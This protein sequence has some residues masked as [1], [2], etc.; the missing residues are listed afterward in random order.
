M[1]WGFVRLA[2]LLLI[3]FG[4]LILTYQAGFTDGIRDTAFVA[5]FVVILI[6]NLLLGWRA[7]AVFFGLSVLAGWAFAYAE[8]QGI[9]VGEIVSA[10][11]LA[12]DITVIFGLAAI[13]L[14]LTTASLGNALQ[15]ARDSERS[16]TDS[17]RELRTLSQSLEQ[18]VTAR[19]QRLQVIAALTEHLNAIL[20]LDELLDEVVNQLKDNF[21]YYHAHIYLMDEERER[22]VVRAGTGQAGAE[23]KA[24]GHSI[25]M[26][27]ATSLVVQAARTGQPVRIDNVQESPD[28]LPNP[29]LPDTR[30]EMVIPI[31]LEQKVVGVLDV[32]KDEVAGLDEGD[33]SLLRSLANQMAVAIRNARLFSEVE[34]A[35]N[36]AREAQQKYVEQSWRESK[37]LG[38]VRHLYAS[39]NINIGEDELQRL[40]D[41]ARK[42]ALT[43]KQPVIVEDNDSLG[44]SL[45]AP[46]NLRE[47][48]IGVFRIRQK[49]GGEQ[50]SWNE[51]DVAMIEAIIDQ[52]AQTAESL[53][54]FEETRRRAGREQ[55]IR[56]VTEHMRA[57]T[58]LD[59]LIRIT[60]EELGQRLS[61]KYAL[62]K[63]GLDTLSENPTIQIN[64]YDQEKTEEER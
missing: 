52:A 48:T 25:S 39:P 46:I 56:Q 61:A 5:Y 15:R 27:A 26:Q 20:N 38:R 47:K 24:R 6:A 13:T 51:D 36:E 40:V 9:I 50:Q 64:D 30:A 45:I 31:I 8:E 10:Y 3:S 63:L 55:T 18:Q 58:N 53:R 28:W 7:G 14:A 37:V 1:R 42:H 33:A 21:N 57:A 11:D 12:L 29:L 17:N 4:W 41:D 44:K 22:L 32:Q 59:E 16:L 34:T 62:V 35:L 19:T 23:M 2:S 54:L 49:D 60:G 43:Q